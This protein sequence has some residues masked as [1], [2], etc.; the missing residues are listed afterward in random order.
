MPRLRR[1]AHVLL[2][3]VALLGGLV[4]FADAG[5]PTPVRSLLGATLRTV[6]NAPAALLSLVGKPVV[7]LLRV[8]PLDGDARTSVLAQV[9]GARGGIV[10]MGRYRVY[11]PAGAWEG[12][13]TVSVSAPD[14]GLLS[15][16]LDV[17]PSPGPRFAR[18]VTVE[19]NTSGSGATDPGITWYDPATGQWYLLAT[20]GDSGSVRA[21]LW[22]F[23]KYGAVGSKAGW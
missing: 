10:S 4:A 17:T 22:H 19:V 16:D 3:T 13:R 2:F 6:V 1:V 21:S 12:V 5:R 15:F 7:D 20:D 14:P 9:D 8:A 11:V 18:M 23:S